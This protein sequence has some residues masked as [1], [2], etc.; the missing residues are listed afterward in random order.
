VK[1][2]VPYL[3]EEPQ[4]ESFMRVYNSKALHWLLPMNEPFS[5]IESQTLSDFYDAEVAYQDRLLSQLFDELETTYH[6]EN[7]LVILVSDHGE[8]LGEQQ[9]MGHSFRV[10]QELIQVPLVIRF[11]RSYQEKRIQNVVST[12][13]LFH[14]IL[15]YADVSGNL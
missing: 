4:A 1:R 11:P 7:T 9:F 10:F 15:D 14:T 8:M 2:F 5:K 3:K 6:R 13:Q 12:S